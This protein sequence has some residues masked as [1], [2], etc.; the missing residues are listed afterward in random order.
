MSA[1][2]DPRGLGASETNPPRRSRAAV[3][4]FGFD[5]RSGDEL[6][7]TRKAVATT[8]TLS[9]GYLV[10]NAAA[11][12]IAGYGL[13]ADSVAVVIGAML[14]AML[15]GPILGIA[16]ALAEA[17]WRLL[18]RAAAAEIVGVLWVLSIGGALGWIHLDVPIGEQIL[19]R[20]SPNI[21]DL[22]IALVGGMAGA[23][24]T[25]SPRLS[26]AVVGVAIATALC[27]P[28]T[29]CGILIAH[30]LPALAE[31]AFLLFVA[32]FAAIATGA[33]AVFMVAGHRALFHD[34]AGHVKW[35]ARLIPLLLLA[36][37]SL[38]LLSVFHA[39]LADVNLRN[40]VRGALDAGLAAHPGARVN[41]LR[42]GRENARR[43]VYA[44]VRSPSAFTST[45]VAQL[46]DAVDRAAGGNVSLH[47]RVVRVEEF[48]RDGRL[49]A[50]AAAIERAP[51]RAR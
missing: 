4:F 49:Y 32:N 48:T 10:M 44:V 8:A 43:V 1:N 20:T 41:D 18:A 45:D 31:G 14:I 5:A 33:M 17:D 26:S 29:A 9:A 38:H 40:Q 3:A 23:Y 39:S 28:L 6:A 7:A 11:T 13:L 24:A 35:T 12:L 16:L 21:L 34:V 22:M 19:A 47:I 50:P 42:V 2:N 25:V 36:A 15:Y 30:G 46:D 51:P 37:L 27:P